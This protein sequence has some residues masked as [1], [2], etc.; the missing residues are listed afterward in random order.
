MTDTGATHELRSVRPGEKP[1]VN[2]R[3]VNLQIATGVRD[4]WMG[5]DEVV[6]VESKVPLQTL[7]PLGTYIE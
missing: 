7:F 5:D 1:D 4:A 3:P 2:V 6:Y